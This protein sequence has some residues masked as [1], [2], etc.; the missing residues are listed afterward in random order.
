[1]LISASKS[2]KGKAVYYAIQQVGVCGSGRVWRALHLSSQVT[3]A[4]QRI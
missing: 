3:R 1:M 2:Q 4:I